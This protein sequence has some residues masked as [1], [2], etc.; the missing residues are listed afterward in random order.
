MFQE[1]ECILQIVV[2]EFRSACR[3]HCGCLKSTYCYKCRLLFEIGYL[4]RLWLTALR[5]MEKMLWYNSSDLESEAEEDMKQEVLRNQQ[6][7][8]ARNDVNG[9][10]EGEGYADRRE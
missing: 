8:W 10:S 5:T 3:W 6:A 2:G 1:R 4:S 9:E 7:E